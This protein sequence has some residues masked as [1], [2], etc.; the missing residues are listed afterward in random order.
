M[1]AFERIQPKDWTAAV[2]ALDA[3]RR[4]NVPAEAKGAGTDLVDRLKERTAAPDRVVDLRRLAT[5]RSIARATGRVSIGALATLTEVAEGL[6]VDF[7]ALADACEGA[8]TP[9]IRNAAT[10]AGNLCQ[11]PRCW[12]FRSA[13]FQ[14]LKKGG[15]ECF[16]RNGENAF[17]AVFGNGTCAIVH[18][19]A[20]GV[21]LLAYGATVETLSPTGSRSIP[22]DSFFLRPEDDIAAENALKGSELIVEIV[23]PTVAGL[24]SAYRKVK[25]KQTSDW[26]LGEVAVAFRDDGGIARNV[27]IVVG[28]AAPVPFRAKKA[29][30]LVEG[31]RIDGALAAAAGQAAL[32]GATPLAQNGYRLPILAA[33]VRR[34][35]LGAAGLPDGTGK[36]DA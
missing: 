13:D 4:A 23:L 33:C 8:A 31:E 25:Q 16:A 11:R 6:R 22:I 18:P 20:A 30:A 34:A 7:P 28:A 1:K 3:A 15:S 26:P 10:I 19:S 21:A 14:C 2:A 32:D 5:H 12:Y 9:Q 27:R 36:A 24:R 35:L 29:E 17:H